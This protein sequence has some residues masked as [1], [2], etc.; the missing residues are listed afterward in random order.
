[1]KHRMNLNDA[2]FRMI[3]S[4]EKTIELRLYDEKRRTVKV[5]D[6]IEFA[7]M[8]NLSERLTAQVTDLHV[9]QSFEELYHELPL[10]KCGYTV[11]NIGTASPDDM[12]IYYSKDEQQKYGVVGIELRLVQPLETE[13]LILRPWEEAD[14]EECYKYAKDPRVDSMD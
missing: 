2:P 6:I 12:D 1:M 14:A 4:G 3:K 11:H 8:G 7:L 9:F 5:G 13:R 10:L